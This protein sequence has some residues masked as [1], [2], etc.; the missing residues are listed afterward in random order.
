MSKT[1]IRVVLVQP[2][3]EINIGSVARI[4]KNFDADELYLVDPI[5]KITDRTREFAAKALDIL[6]KIVVVKT[7]REALSAVDLSV[8]TSAIVGGEKDVLRHPITPWQLVDIV[9]DKEKIAV[10]FGRESVGLTR[11]E[12]AQCDILVTI[13]ANPKY[14][15]LNLSHAVAVIL[16]ELYKSLKIDANK[17]ELLY[18][19]ASNEIIELILNYFRRILETLER[20]ERRKEKIYVSFR[21]ILNK[22]IPSDAEAHNILYIMR[23]I[24]L[25][26]D[27]IGRDN[28]NN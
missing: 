17:G 22:S 18:K 1:R 26:V 28:G 13:P 16:Y 19:P 5:A 6:E 20:D 2:E 23:K 25:L 21:R 4:V 9:K 3:G 11:D 7:L 12:I 14:P 10:V 24:S 27:K 8:C 15:T